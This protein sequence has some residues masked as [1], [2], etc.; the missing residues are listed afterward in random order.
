VEKLLLQ[1]EFQ[2]S[3]AAGDSFVL[4]GPETGQRPVALGHLNAR[5]SEQLRLNNDIVLIL[6][7]QQRDFV[8]SHPVAAGG[9]YDGTDRPRG[10]SPEYTGRAPR[11]RGV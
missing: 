11:P 5:P 1:K 9:V 2:Y 3:I 8:T 10:S 4:I 6:V 7:L